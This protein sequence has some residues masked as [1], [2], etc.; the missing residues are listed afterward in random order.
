MDKFLENLKR[1]AE[2][3]PTW[4]LAAIGALFAGAAKLMNAATWKREVA[5]R[6]MKVT[7]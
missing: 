7:K 4:T 3:N 1:E 2:A 5:R 6:A